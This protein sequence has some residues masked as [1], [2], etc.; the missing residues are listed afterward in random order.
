MTKIK[1]EFNRE[2]YEARPWYHDFS[3]LGVQTHFPETGIKKL[4]SDYSFSYISKRFFKNPI[5][6]M[7]SLI[8]L[9]S[10]KSSKWCEWALKNQIEKEKFILPYIDTAIKS[11]RKNSIKPS[12]LEMFCA[13]GY[14]S[15][16]MKKR[17]DIGDMTAIDI[18]ERSIEL[19]KTM[20]HILN[21][22]IDFK[23][24]DV[25]NLPTNKKYN[26]VLCAGGL[27]HLKDPK[28]LIEL[29][30]KITDNFL[31]IQSVI[32]METED[33]NYFISPAPGWKHGS[34][35]TDSKLRQWIVDAGF[36]IVK[37]E[38]NKLHANKKLSD[39]GSTYYLC[40]KV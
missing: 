30:Y 12:V 21:E 39:R 35:F 37:H 34:R 13:D 2:I 22:K 6:F 33:K 19:G 3:S 18:D 5:N 32:T 16:W 14:Y 24:L 25:F 10:S 8:N 27:Y 11:C 7:N 28:E 1:A 17:Y 9:L 15:F 26:I 38:R 29:A 31:I 36:K 23:C 20:N 4:T 40:K